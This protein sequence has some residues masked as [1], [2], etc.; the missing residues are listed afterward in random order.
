MLDCVTSL[1]KTLQGFPRLPGVKG[2]GLIGGGTFGSGI[3]AE[4]NKDNRGKGKRSTD[5]SGGGKRTRRSQ[6][7]NH[8]IF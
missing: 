6:K 1:L 3:K 8:H 5:K 4:M 2:Q 7:T